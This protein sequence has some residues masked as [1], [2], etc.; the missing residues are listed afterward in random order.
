MCG[1]MV[2]EDTKRESQQLPTVKIS[3]TTLTSDKYGWKEGETTRFKWG[4]SVRVTV[5]LTFTGCIVGVLTHPRD[6][7]AHQGVRD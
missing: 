3:Q 2:L 4:L 1:Y 7:L 5:D 6:H